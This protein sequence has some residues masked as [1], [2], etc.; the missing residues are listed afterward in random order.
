MAS[1][2]ACQ[3]GERLRGSARM[4]GCAQ[5]T[6]RGHKSELTSRH[7]PHPIPQKDALPVL[8]LIPTLP[9]PRFVGLLAA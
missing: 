5:G 6:D 8:Q 4:K 1:G 7:L 3:D 9:V 2:A